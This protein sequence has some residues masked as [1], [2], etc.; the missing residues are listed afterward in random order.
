MDNELILQLKMTYVE[1]GLFFLFF[2]LSDFGSKKISQKYY[3][4]IRTDREASFMFSG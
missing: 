1:S 2:F 4:F 3:Y